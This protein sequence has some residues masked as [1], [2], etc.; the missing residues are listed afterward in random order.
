MIC[1]MTDRVNCNQALLLI[2]LKPEVDIIFQANL[3]EL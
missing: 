1:K 3:L 2:D